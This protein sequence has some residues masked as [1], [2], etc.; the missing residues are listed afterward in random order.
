MSPLFATHASDGAERWKVEIKLGV[1]HNV[2]LLYVCQ[3]TFDD[4]TLFFAQIT[5]IFSLFQGR[6]TACYWKAKQRGIA[7]MNYLL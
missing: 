4:T 3:H 1:N 6:S 2:C 7:K 5:I